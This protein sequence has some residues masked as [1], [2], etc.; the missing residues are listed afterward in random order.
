M[1]FRNK[2]S[3]NGSG[4]CK[5]REDTIMRKKLLSLATAAVMTVIFLTGCSDASDPDAFNSDSICKTAKKY[6]MTEAKSYSEYVAVI[7]PDEV[8]YSSVYY[9]IRNS[10]EA[11][12]WYWATYLINE[13]PSPEN[14]LAE[15]VLCMDYH[16]RGDDNEPDYMTEI[17]MF[18]AIDEKT[19]VELYERLSQLSKYDLFSSGENN[20]YSYSIS[21]IGTET[22][23]M[24]IGVYKKGNTVIYINNGGDIVKENNC[25]EFF[26][27][28]LGLV[29]P[30]TLK[31]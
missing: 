7:R 26:C 17:Y 16:T 25:A 10:R 21:Y 14:I 19:A 11:N 30:M 4:F 18:T 31:K 27:K 2:D 8:D 3:R 5:S 23:R 28:E 24:A 22:R 9:D 29:S 6:G 13:S 1:I 20:G 12:E 15:C